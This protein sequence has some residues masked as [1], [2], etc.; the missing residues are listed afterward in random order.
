[1]KTILQMVLMGVVGVSLGLL[2]NALSSDPLP[3]KAK[4]EQ[5]EV[6]VDETIQ[7]PSAEI[8]DLWVSGEGF[9][10][11]ARGAEAYTEGRI[12]GAFSLPYKSFDDGATP[13]TI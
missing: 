12:P 3:L 2:A 10:V 11:D 8:M 7:V 1:M 6:K 13:E 4:A 9:F 5:F